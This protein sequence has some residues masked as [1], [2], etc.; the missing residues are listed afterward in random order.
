MSVEDTYEPYSVN[1]WTSWKKDCLDTIFQVKSELKFHGINLYVDENLLWFEES[2][3]RAENVH[4]N[5]EKYYN[6][7]DFSDNE[8]DEIVEFIKKTTSK[9]IRKRRRKRK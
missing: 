9:M 8:V 4:T 2:S 7:W 1:A 5:K 3:I 6:I